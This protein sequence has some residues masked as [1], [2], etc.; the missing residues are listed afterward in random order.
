MFEVDA[1]RM[2]RSAIGKGLKVPAKVGEIGAVK[3]KTTT[4]RGS[5]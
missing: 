5:G 1:H 2:R 4:E 3:G